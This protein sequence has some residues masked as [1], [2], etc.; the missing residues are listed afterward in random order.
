M[1]RKPTTTHSTTNKTQRKPL[2]TLKLTRP[3]SNDAPEPPIKKYR[4]GFVVCSRKGSALINLVHPSWLSHP[5]VFDLTKEDTIVSSSSQGS[6]GSS[7]LPKSDRPSQRPRGDVKG[8][9]KETETS[10]DD[11]DSS[12]WVDKYEPT[13]EVRRVPSPCYGRHSS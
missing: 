2:K 10:A 11:E 1:S 13:S 9:N 6:A 5:P 3:D 7:R 4:A 8:K 12:L